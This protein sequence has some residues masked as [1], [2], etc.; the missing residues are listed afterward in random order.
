MTDIILTKEDPIEIEISNSESSITVS[1]E[2]NEIIISKVGVQG[3][4]GADGVGV[5]SGGTT[6]Q[7]LAK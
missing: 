6:G 5:P 4:K 3:A 2:S 1:N 7:V